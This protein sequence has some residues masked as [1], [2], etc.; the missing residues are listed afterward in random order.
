MLAVVTFCESNAKG[1]WPYI[2]W[3]TRETLKR[4]MFRENVY[5]F[6]Y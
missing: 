3:I 4:K 5:V 1:V 2:T 6:S